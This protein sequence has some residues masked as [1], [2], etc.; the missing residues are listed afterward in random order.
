[1]VEEIRREG[2]VHVDI[3]SLA[4]DRRDPLST[5]RSVLALSRVIRDYEID[6]VHGHNAAATWCAWMASKLVHFPRGLPVTQSVR[7][8]ELRPTHQWR[9][10][11]YRFMPA[12]LFAVCEYTKQE[13]IARTGVAS[14][15]VVVTYNGVDLRRFNPEEVT[16]YVRDEIGIPANAF[17]VGV[18]AALNDWKGQEVLLAAAPAVLAAHPNTY[19]LMV[20]KGPQE[21]HLRRQA[22]QLGVAQRVLFTGFRRDIP[23]VLKAIDLFVL[24]SK[25]GE[26][27]PNVLVEATS[28]GLPFVASNLSGIPELAANEGVGLLVT[29]GESTELAEAITQLL[30]D[31]ERRKKMGELG[32]QRAHMLF[33]ITAVVDRI[34]KTYTR[35]LQETK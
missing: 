24:P 15:R 8:L 22:R 11:I 4:V 21:E 14:E 10:L 28:M 20:G 34:E 19:F 7:G 23:A 2:F 35:L 26:M 3:P 31:P 13:L 33:T 16:S 6:I 12:T 30:G 9:N 5:L 32:R 1:M 25:K 17:V 29:P 27:F 18:V